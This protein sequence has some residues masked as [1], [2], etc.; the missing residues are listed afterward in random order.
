MAQV[1]ADLDGGFELLV[2][3]YQHDV[4]TLA[5]RW[6]ANRHDAEDLAQDTF[7]SAYR[8]LR[9]YPAGQLASLRPRPFLL[10]IALNGA[11]NGARRARRRPGWVPLEAGPVPAAPGG[12]EEEAERGRGGEAVAARLA[13]IPERY[14]LPV[15][16]RCVIGL[17]YAEMGE[18]TGVPLG[19]LKSQVS[20]GLALLREA[21]SSTEEVSP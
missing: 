4:F 15:V 10:T 9:R 7:V 11:R 13:A 1:A 21:G 19:T 12:P 20:R 17:G 5:L 14:R 8:A 6:T 16:L 18:V 3:R 2:R